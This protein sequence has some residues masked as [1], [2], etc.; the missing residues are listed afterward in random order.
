MSTCPSTCPPR[1]PPCACATATTSRSWRRRARSPTRPST[2]S[3]S[4]SSTLGRRGRDVGRGRVPRAPSGS[5]IRDVTVSPN[6]FSTRPPT[7]AATRPTS[8]ADSHARFEPG[9]I[10]AGDWA[11][12]LGVAAVASQ[13]EGDADGEVAFRV[14]IDTRPAAAWATHS[15]R[16]D[17]VRP[18]RPPTRTPAGTPATSTFTASTSPATRH[19]RDLRLRVRAARS[20]RRGAGLDF[21]TLVDHNNMVAYGEI[22][23]YQRRL[24]GQADHPQHRG[25]DLSRPYPEPRQRPLRRLPHRPALEAA[26]ADA[27]VNRTV[28]SLELEGE[29]PARLGGLRRDPCRRRLHPDQPPD[30][31]PVG[32]ARPSTTSAAAARG[33]TPPP[34]PTTRRSTRSRSRPGPPGS[35]RPPPGAEPVHA[36]RGPLLGGRDRL[37]RR[38]LNRSPPS[39]SS[40]SHQ[41]TP[42]ARSTR[43]GHGAPIGMATTVV[44]AEELSEEGIQDAVAGGAHLRQAVGRRRARPAARGERSG[45]RRRRRSSATRSRATRRASPRG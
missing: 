28:A 33:A 35:D 41:A 27:G 38:Q 6:G 32:G 39:A 3:T 14:E 23:R 24:P 15:L 16:A 4:A 1:R 26:L 13:Q 12:E 25:D 30:D 36:A 20:R 43:R 5:S 9:P 19:A 37:R 18:G 40:D 29:P 2:C 8:Q 34:R 17:P 31:L 22:G 11:V 10:P 42:A 44:H 7:R 21:V 45:Q